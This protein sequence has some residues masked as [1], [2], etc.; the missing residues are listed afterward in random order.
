MQ[1]IAFV[2]RAEGGVTTA[3]KLP[4][5]FPPQRIAEVIGGVAIGGSGNW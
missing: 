1:C 5:Y 3:L 4:A 2:N